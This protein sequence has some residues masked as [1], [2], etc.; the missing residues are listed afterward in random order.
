MWFIYFFGLKHAKRTFV[1][2]LWKDLSSSQEVAYQS[3]SEAP[4]IYLIGIWKMTFQK[5]VKSWRSTGDYVKHWLISHLQA[6]CRNISCSAKSPASCFVR[7]VLL[8]ILTFV[9]WVM[10][11]EM[12]NVL[13]VCRLL[14]VAFWLFVSQHSSQIFSCKPSCSATFCHYSNR[15][16]SWSTGLLFTVHFHFTRGESFLWACD[17][18]LNWSSNSLIIPD[19]LMPHLA[20]S[21][22]VLHKRIFV[23]SGQ[24]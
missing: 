14:P 18:G 7:A 13:R 10:L 24:Q 22:E 1:F 6:G 2:R 20:F 11:C 12:H 8:H 9:T 5:G 15:W 21:L 4:L 23:F 3:P 19:F 16:S 17:S